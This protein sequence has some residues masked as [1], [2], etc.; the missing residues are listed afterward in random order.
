[1][2]EMEAAFRGQARRLALLEPVASFLPILAVA[3]IV[4]LSLVLLGVQAGQVLPGL[5]TFVLA[6]QRLNVRL[7]GIANSWN[8][9]ADNSARLAL[10]DQIL[11]RSDKQ[12]RRIGGVPFEGLTRQIRFDAVGLRYSQDQ[13]A[14]LTQL[15]FNLPRGKPWRSWAPVVLARAPS[16]ICWWGCMSHRRVRSGWMISP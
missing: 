14:A 3:V 6:L 12:F 11:E 9:L 10:T 5:V 8:A 13:P 7:G 16:L 2:G 15:S 1:M 4:S